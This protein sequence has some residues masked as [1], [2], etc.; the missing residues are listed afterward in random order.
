MS[1]YPVSA[2]ALRPLPDKCS[3]YWDYENMPIPRGCDS[4]AVISKLRRKLW[5]SI[6]SRIPIDFKVYIRASKVTQRIQDD[7]DINGITHVHV[8]S[9]KP[10]SVDKRMM[11]DI[12]F[13]LYELERDSKSRSIAL[14]SGDKGLFSFRSHL[15]YSLHFRSS[16]I[17]NLYP[18]P[19][20]FRIFAIQNPRHSARLQELPYSAPTGPDRP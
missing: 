15:I 20:R 18:T 7:F 9:T 5:E 4:A 10:E 11:V 1:L 19:F 2:L 3:V 13:S 12:T 8:P 17:Y 16:D 14:I 6:G